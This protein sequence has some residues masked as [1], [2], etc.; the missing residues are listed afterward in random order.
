VKPVLAKVM[1]FHRT[2]ALATT[3]AALTVTPI[4]I[5]GSAD[6]AAASGAARYSVSV[7]HCSGGIAIKAYPNRAVAARARL[8]AVHY[9]K[10]HPASLRTVALRHGSKVLASSTRSC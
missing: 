9:Q 10:H 4:A 3:A 1:G 6:A 8:K 2:L 7:E 5:A